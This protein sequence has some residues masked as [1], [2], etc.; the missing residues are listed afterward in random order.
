MDCERHRYN[1]KKGEREKRIKERTNG[2]GIIN[3]CHEL[4]LNRNNNL[5]EGLPSVFEGEATS[6]SLLRRK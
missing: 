2:E 5:L 6:L 4:D 3:V 1:K